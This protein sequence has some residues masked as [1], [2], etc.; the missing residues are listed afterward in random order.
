MPYSPHQTKNTDISDECLNC[1]RFL[2]KKDTC[3][4]EIYTTFSTNLQSQCL[5]CHGSKIPQSCRLFC[6]ED[7]TFILLGQIPSLSLPLF[8]RKINC[9]SCHIVHTLES[10]FLREEYFPLQK[11]L[12]AINPH[13]TGIFCRLCH[14]KE[15]KEQGDDPQLLFQGDTVRLC[16]S[17]H[18]GKKI[19]SDNHPINI[20]PASGRGIKIPPTFPLKRGKIVCITCHD[21]MQA[22]KNNRYFLRNGPY[23]RP[24]DSCLQCHIDEGYRKINPHNLVTAQGS[25]DENKCLFCHYI[26]SPDQPQVAFR[27]KAPFRFYCVGCHPIKVKEHPVMA[28]HTGKLI[29]S[30]WKELNHRQKKKLAQQEIFTMFPFSIAGEILCITC[31]NPHDS[32]KGPKLRISPA[33]ESCRQCH[34]QVYGLTSE[35]PDKHIQTWLKYNN[36]PYNEKTPSDKELNPSTENSYPFSFRSSLRFYCIGCHP[37]CKENHPYGVTHTGKFL[38]SFVSNKENSNFRQKQILPLTYCG[39][40]NC[41]SCHN[42][43]HNEAEGKKLRINDKQLLCSLCHRKKID[44]KDPETNKA[45]F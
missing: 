23:S 27:F 24:I 6:T 36:A 43:H 15:P 7:N 25:I 39:R 38:E 17:C 11:Q 29:S 12:D 14:E 16:K 2:P 45:L 18:D 20:T 10:S 32:R 19:L 4:Q 28:E 44:I 8:N 37:N 3:L 22:Q 26:I 42:P 30:L 41:F 1:H 21:V 40:I 35:D 5:A 9:I 33:N 31:H 13:K 34:Y